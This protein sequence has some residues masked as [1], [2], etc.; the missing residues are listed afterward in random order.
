MRID[1]L[2]IFPEVVNSYMSSSIMNRARDKGALEFYAHDLR[3]WTDDFHRT[4]DDAPY[5]GGQGMV[6][7]PEPLFKAIEAISALDG[8]CPY[9][10]F[11]TPAGR[12]FKQQFAQEFSTHER[13]LF[14][15]G[16]YE[17][18][19]QRVIDHFADDEISIGDYVLTGGELAALT[20]SDAVVRLLP[21]VLGNELSSVEESFSEGLLEYP[22]YTRPAE[23]R[24][25]EV[26][27]V[28][29]SGNHG[30]V[31]KWRAEQSYNRT[32]TRR[33]DLLE[34]DE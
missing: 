16:R 28:L 17:G 13:I 22:Q 10:V 7:M 18:I 1:I 32:Q 23:F 5:G 34:N 24:G 12:V 3:N 20:V 21:E 30:E 27:P 19:D 29:L 26:P 8:R 6:M 25:Y 9:I 4:V 33:P 2:T 31:A 15:C 14:V 11:T